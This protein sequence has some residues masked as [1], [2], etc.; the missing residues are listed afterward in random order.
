MSGKSNISGRE[1]FHFAPQAI[2]G[3]MA[4]KFAGE[5]QV[6]ATLNKVL[7]S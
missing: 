3:D 2:E 1:V 5:Q 7:L 6:S 4:E